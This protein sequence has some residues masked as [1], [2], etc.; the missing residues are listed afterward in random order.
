MRQRAQ[1][2]RVSSR[3]STLGNA[4]LPYANLPYAN[5]PYAHLPYALLQSLSTRS[6]AK[7]RRRRLATSRRSES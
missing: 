2:G 4:N 1:C 3:P 6:V 7:Q 5:L